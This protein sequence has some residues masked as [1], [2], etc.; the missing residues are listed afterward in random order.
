MVTSRHRV[1]RL[2]GTIL[3][4]A[5]AGEA[6]AAGLPDAARGVWQLAVDTQTC[7]AKDWGRRDSQLRISAGMIEYW[8][9][10][11]TITSIGKTP[12]GAHELKLACTGEGE[13]WSRTQHWQFATLGKETVAASAEPEDGSVTLYK[14]CR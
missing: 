10:T 12:G 14:K 6:S 9:T 7:T 1:I 4:I 2:I 8:E 3:F 11:C 5:A 13:T